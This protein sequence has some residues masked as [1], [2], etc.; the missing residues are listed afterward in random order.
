MDPQTSLAGQGPKACRRAYDVRDIRRR[1][2]ALLDI[3]DLA[4]CMRIARGGMRDIAEVLY[5]EVEFD[6]VYSE[7]AEPDN[8]SA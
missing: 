3:G 5:E 4:R 8:V 1:I 7:V 6:T 2:F